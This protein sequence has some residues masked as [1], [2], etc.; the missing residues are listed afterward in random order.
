MEKQDQ[1]QTKKDL[2]RQLD[3]LLR[4]KNSMD[5]VLDN[6]NKLEK[7]LSKKNK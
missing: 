5:V 3:D 6:V 4:I 7:A 1:E 2:K